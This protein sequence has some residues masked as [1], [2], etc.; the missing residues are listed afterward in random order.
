VTA[1]SQSLTVRVPLPIHRRG[2]RKVIIT[3][4]GSAPDAAPR[5]TR[6]DP[7]LVKALAR[8]HRWK[9]LLESGRYASISE[10]AATE[11]ID[12]G[13]LGRI[14][15]LTLLAPD[16]VQA[17]LDGK[18]PADLT[19]PRLMKPFPIIW[20]EQRRALDTLSQVV[21]P[22]ECSALC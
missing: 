13:Y 8:A 7:T 4:Q 10:M 22:E 19:L 3:P 17:I 18:H 9:S 5:K 6:L 20:A 11:K 14:L 15:L 1:V 16:I 2:R 21:E 12:R